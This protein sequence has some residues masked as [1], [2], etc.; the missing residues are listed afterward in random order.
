MIKFFCEK[1]GKEMWHLPESWDYVKHLTLEDARR[2]LLCSDCLL[3]EMKEL[4]I[5]QIVYECA[6]CRGRWLRHQLARVGGGLHPIYVCPICSGAI[7]AKDS[8]VIQEGEEVISSEDASCDDK[9]IA[10]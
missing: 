7:I 2:L 3:A 1:C 10:V 6:L 4:P 5:G 8:L 9:S